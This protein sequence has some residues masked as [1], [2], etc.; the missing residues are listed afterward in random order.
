[1]GLVDEGRLTFSIPL[2][3]S[4]SAHSSG[5]SVTNGESDFESLGFTDGYEADYT[6]VQRLGMTVEVDELHRVHFE[7]FHLSS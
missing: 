3:G 4:E 2:R 5:N 7:R 6:S 1:M